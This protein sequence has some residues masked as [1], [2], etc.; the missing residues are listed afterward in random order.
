[1]EKIVLLSIVATLLTAYASAYKQEDL[2]KLQDTY[3]CVKCDL[4]GAILREANLTRANLYKAELRKADLSQV[5]LYKAS[6][7]KANLYRANLKKADLKR[8]NL[9]NALLRGAMLDSEDLMDAK[10]SN[11]ILPSGNSTFKDC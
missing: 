2:D 1:M 6:L 8:A 10:F 4:R 7:H 5:I 9:F 3:N 11:T